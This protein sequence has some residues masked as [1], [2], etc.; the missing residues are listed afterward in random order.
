M[1]ENATP[2]CPECDTPPEAL[3]RR[4]F[5]RQTA[6]VVALGAVAG[7]VPHL[8]AADKAATAPAKKPEKPAEALVKELF[9]GLSTDQ[10]K[11]IVYPWEDK[12]RFGMYN[13]PFARETTIGKTYTKA[14]QG[15]IDRIVRAIASDEDGYRQ[16]SR[17]GTWDGSHALENCGAYIFGDPAQGKYAWLFTGHHLTVRCDGDSEEGAAFGGPMYY[18][19]SPNG[20]S[21]RNIFYYQTKAVLSVFE[22]L[23]EKQRK[24]AIVTGTPGEHAPSVRFRPAKER[25]PGISSG[26]LNKG[27]RALV[28]TVMRTILSPYR[29]QDADEV[30]EI[31]KTN[32]G[33]EKIHLAFY[34]DGKMN[35]KEPWHFW[36]LEGPGFVWNFRVLPHVHTYVN[37]CL[38]S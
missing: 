34:Q 22:A 6:G 29:K 28:E 16:L 15:L 4:H 19:H 31:I 14:Q 13:G 38:Q 17:N 5:I 18:G 30:M 23:S 8:P 36:R 9:A 33:L 21:D 1:S 3:D 37:C 2:F 27:Q 26:E 25:K 7:A 10:K 12:R 11:A 35:D 24:V 32:G 20:Y